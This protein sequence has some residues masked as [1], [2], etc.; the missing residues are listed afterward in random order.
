NLHQIGRIVVTITTVF[1]EANP[2]SPAARKQPMLWHGLLTV[3]PAGPCFLGVFGAVARN[4][5]CPII[6]RS[7]AIANFWSRPA[8]AAYCG[9]VI[10]PSEAE[11]T[12]A[13]YL[14]KT[15]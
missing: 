13:A 2:S 7:G 8:P 12:N 1:H 9:R 14:A 4:S 3:P 10:A 5:L 15:P 11:E 6:N